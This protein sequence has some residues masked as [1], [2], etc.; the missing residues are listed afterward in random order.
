MGRDDFDAVMFAL[1]SAVYA[2]Q[3]FEL[4]LGTTLIA[5]TMA[6]GDRSKFPDE[7]AVRTWLDEV[8]SLTIGRLKGKLKALNLL[9][10]QMVEDIGEINRMRIEVVHHF[11]NRWTELIEE[12]NGYQTAIGELNAYEAVFW[13]SAKKLHAGIES[14][15]EMKLLN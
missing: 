9:P 14:L 4:N 10:D 3:A 2:A 1:G 13:A 15:D 5:L 11:S 8:A 12:A 6:K 7:E